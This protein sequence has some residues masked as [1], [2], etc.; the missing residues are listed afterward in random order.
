MALLAF[1]SAPLKILFRLGLD[2]GFFRIY[3]DLDSEAERRRLAGTVALFSVFVGAAL[4]ALGLFGAPAIADL[5]SSH[6]PPPSRWVVLTFA[7]LF[8]GTFALLPQALLRIQGRARTFTAIA[9]GRHATGIVLKVTLLRWGW[10][11][12]AVLWSDLV[13]TAVYVL[14]QLPI[15][16]A[17]ARPAWVPS[18][19]A[20]VLHFGTPKVPHGLLVQ[21]QNLADR[22]ILES[23]V[24]RADL[25]LYHIGYTVAG[26]VKFPISAFEQAW[27]PFVYAQLGK[28]EASRTLSRVGTY[29]FAA[30]AASGLA[31]ALFG[32]EALRLLTK[33]AFHDAAPIIP[34]VVLAYVIH[35]FFLLTSVGIGIEKKARYYPL[36]TL[37]AASANLAGNFALIPRWGLL[38]AAWATAFSY[39]VMASVGLYFSQRLHPLPIEWGRYLRLSVAAGALFALSR[40]TPDALVLALATKAVLLG[41]F[42]ALLWLMGFWTPAELR[43]LRG[44]WPRGRKSTTAASAG[45]SPSPPA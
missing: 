32:R 15:L 30:F 36:I 22:R 3:Y 1:L 8:L 11:V 33:P 39:T 18:L 40:F 31:V 20:R 2:A 43:E 28:P 37:A 26:A 34:V 29:F 10:G 6:E 9:L 13:A 45:G 16:I 4:F 5:L 44:L 21:A 27:Q 7:D 14:V 38:G 19:L 23:Y 17:H 41:A 35:G 24:A 25:G 12:D 42:P